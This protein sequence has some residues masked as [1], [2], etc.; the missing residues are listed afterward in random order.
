MRS[1]LKRRDI[2]LSYA[3]MNIEFARR[4]KVTILIHS[5]ITLIIHL[6]FTASTEQCW[7]YCV[8]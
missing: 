4:I 8:D 1:V 7:L 5:I 3:H 2:F 6:L